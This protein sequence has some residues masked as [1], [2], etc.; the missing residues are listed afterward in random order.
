M[1]TAT[2]FM[3]D[4]SGFTKF[5]N[6][7]EQEHSRHIISELI[8]L[9]IKVGGKHFEI[10]E[11]EGDAVFFYKQKKYSLEKVTSIARK[12][13]AKFHSHLEQYA[14]KRICECGACTTAAN[15]AVK[16]IVHQGDIGLINY[17]GGTKKP[18]GK[19]VIEVHRLLKNKIGYQEYLLF[20]DQFLGELETEEFHKG[21]YMDSE[22]GSIPFQYQLIGDWEKPKDFVSQKSSTGSF[23][24]SV[25][26]KIELDYPP[27]LIHEMLVNFKFRQLWNKGADKIIY[28]KNEINQAGTAH[29]CVVNGKELYFDTI[30][31]EVSDG[32]LAYG[33][34]LKNPSPFSYLE[35]D[36][37]LDEGALPGNTTLTH[38][39]R[40]KYKSKVQSILSFVFRKI[41]EKKSK[42]GLKDIK[43]A[44]P[45]FLELKTGKELA[46]S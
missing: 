42:D 6:E 30:K 13:H 15:L 5:L 3:P 27:E 25:T 23:D 44:I 12:I 9:I 38:V 19:T 11:I 22:L 18:F 10:A 17:D 21:E 40:V 37:F 32:Q 26:E 43:E 33:E 34:I 7:T 46:Y 35:I 20:S 41:V 39:T 24:L 36:Y 2:L 8:G 16:F 4:I 14:N 28:D 29:Y 1:P 45:A 31:P